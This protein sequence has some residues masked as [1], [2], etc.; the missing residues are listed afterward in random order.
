MLYN[1]ENAAKN[2]ILTC[3]RAWYL[4]LRR[5]CTRV[6]GRGFGLEKPFQMLVMEPDLR[7][8]FLQIQNPQYCLFHSPPLVGSG[9]HRES[10]LR[11][12]WPRNKGPGSPGSLGPRNNFPGSTCSKVR[13]SDTSLFSPLKW[14]LVL[15][16][17]NYKI[18]LHTAFS[19]F[20]QGWRGNSV[21]KSAFC[22]CRRPSPI[23]STY[24]GRLTI[25]HSRSYWESETLSFHTDKAPAQ[26]HISTRTCA[27]TYTRAHTFKNSFKMLK[28]HFV[29]DYDQVS[30]RDP[31]HKDLSRTNPQGTGDQNAP[32]FS[33]F[34]SEDIV[35]VME[36]AATSKSFLKFR[37]EPSIKRQ[38]FKNDTA[39][40]SPPALCCSSVRS[41]EDL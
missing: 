15:K 2:K 13:V 8:V 18:V 33:S 22:C 14:E 40:P 32:E 1:W 24:V 6:F 31:E 41:S 9:R 5:G 30:R 7:T 28:S 10:P 21:V 23:P 37:L 16:W 39:F 3:R 20:I 11:K 17:I 38:Q 27:D 4:Q 29:F 25:T 19:F 34:T 12:L 26:A 35:L 36:S